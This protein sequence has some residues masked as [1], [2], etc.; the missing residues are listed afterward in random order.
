ML[1]KPGTALYA[2]EVSKESGSKVL[3][4]NYLGASF[5]PNVAENQ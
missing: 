5:V 4:I 2:Y 3:Y 1:F